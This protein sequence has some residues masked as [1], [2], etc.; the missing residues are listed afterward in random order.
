M[1]GLEP[2]AV[3][4]IHD[5][6]AD[7]HLMTNKTPTVNKA[8]VDKLRRRDLINA[9]DWKEWQECEWKQL[10]QYNDQKLFGT[11]FQRDYKKGLFILVWT[12]YYKTDGSNSRKARFTCDGSPR[13]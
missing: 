2:E 4:H 13:A 8:L 10:N 6:L 5:I 7:V 1:N 3:H 9:T 12:H 11:P